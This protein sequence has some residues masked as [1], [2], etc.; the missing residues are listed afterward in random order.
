MLNRAEL[1]G[2]LGADP[3][4]KESNNGKAITKL[5]IATTETWNDKATGD[6]KTQ[7]EWHNVVAFGEVATQ[8]SKNLW[9]GT[10]VYI[11]GK[12]KTN[13]YEDKDG[14]KRMSTSITADKIRALAP[15]PAPTEGNRTPAPTP[16]SSADDL[17]F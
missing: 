10:L 6:R 15:S 5:R 17:P 14:V 1:I 4:T 13:S 16:E 9:K 11:E 12:I 8:A 3:E 7:T 2:R